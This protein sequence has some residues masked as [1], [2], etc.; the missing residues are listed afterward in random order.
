[1]PI[2]FLVYG[3]VIA[4]VSQSPRRK[5][6]ALMAT[7]IGLFIMGNGV[8]VN[9][10]TRLWEYAPRTLKPEE[11]YDLAVV[12]TGGI[13]D[14]KG[15]RMHFGNS[16]DRI[17]QP[18]LLYREGKIR[19]ILISGGSGMTSES[20]QADSAAEGK[21]AAYLLEIAGVPK[22]HI[23]LEGTSRN[24]RENAKNTAKILKGK[25]QE[26][27]LVTS[28]FHMRRAVGCFEKV[29]LKV[30][31][32]PTDFYASDQPYSWDQLLIPKEY[33]LYCL[34]RIIHEILG[35]SVYTILGYA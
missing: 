8:F 32:F 15:D 33:N 30:S 1:M 10:L 34:Y 11:T 2:S 5:K 4:V 12:L 9:E 7:L 6:R 28:A 24:T 16:A 19:K 25:Q 31:P 22:E 17:L 20:A 21:A 27:L 18:L 35:Y 14:K 3:L 26:I 23:I 13:A 29:N